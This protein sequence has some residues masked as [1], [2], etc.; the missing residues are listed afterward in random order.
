MTKH[1]TEP[2]PSVRGLRPDAPDWID[3]VIQKAT[4][5]DRALRFQSCEEMRAMVDQYDGGIM[6]PRSATAFENSIIPE[7]TGSNPGAGGYGPPPA[8]GSISGGGTSVMS[9]AGYAAPAIPASPSRASIP[10][11][12]GGSMGIVIGIVAVLA[13]GGG[14][15]FFLT[16]GD[17]SGKNASGKT[18]ETKDPETK[19]P[20]ETKEPKHTA[21]AANT[22]NTGKPPTEKKDPLKPLLGMWK[23]EGTGR[24]LKAVKDGEE[25]D[26]KVVK[27]DQFGGAYSKDEVRFSLKKGD[28]ETSYY[29][30]DRYRP[31]P[32]GKKYGLDGLSSCLTEFTTD[33]KGQTLTSTLKSENTLEVQLVV[34]TVTVNPPVNGE[35]TSCGAGKF[36][37]ITK[38]V[39]HK[40]DDED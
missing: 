12:K 30:V 1:M 33:D 37:S 25:I 29:V 27:P 38:S 5:K 20:K 21:T 10:T 13:I 32:Q 39:F 24:L 17:D 15:V 19:A 16:R 4:Q 8:A 35:I 34:S 3:M 7:H 31:N 36:A 6:V 18:P 26:F 9:N 11:K 23:A 28:D 14:A 40:S 2:V 22:E